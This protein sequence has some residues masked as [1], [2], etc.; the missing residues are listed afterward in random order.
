MN[1]QKSFLV[2]LISLI[3]N[4]V[5]AQ[6]KTTGCISGDCENGYGIRVYKNGSKYKGDWKN[7]KRDGKGTYDYYKGHKYIGLWSKNKKHG[8]GTMYSSR[9]G[10]TESGIWNGGFTVKQYYSNGKLKSKGKTYLGKKTSH[11]D[12]YDSDGNKTRAGLYL[13]DKLHGF[14]TFYYKGT[15]RKKDEGYFLKGN[16]D[17]GWRHYSYNGTLEYRN[18]YSD[19]KR[20]R[21][22]SYY[23]NGKK[24]W[25]GKVYREKQTGV[26]KKYNRNGKLNY[27]TTYRNGKAIS[28]KRY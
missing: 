11:W 5:V 10:V 24:E 28:S 2:I 25:G 9:G 21:H 23:S 12:F 15:E 26:W 7:G 6:K 13:K 22:Q 4:T 1:I 14:W 20:I 18:S 27:T 17:N 19:G 16:K 3:F 8:Q